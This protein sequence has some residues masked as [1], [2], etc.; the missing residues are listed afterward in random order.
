MM[1]NLDSTGRSQLSFDVCLVRCLPGIGQAIDMVFQTCWIHA[2]QFGIALGVCY[3]CLATVF[4]RLAA[5]PETAIAGAP[6][7]F[8]V[9][10]T[11]VVDDDRRV[12]VDTELAPFLAVFDAA[13][14]P[15]DEREGKGR[16]A[17]PAQ[18]WVS[19]LQDP[20]FGKSVQEAL[21]A[22]LVS[23]KSL[24]RLET[25]RGSHEPYRISDHELATRL[26]YFL[27]ST[28]PDDE[29]LSVAE[30]NK[31]S[32]P[33]VLE[34]QVKRMMADPKASA[35]ADNFAGQ[36]LE[37][38]NLDSIAPDPVKFPAWGQELKEE[39]RTETRMFFQYVLTENRPIS[40]FVNAKYTFLNGMAS[41]SANFASPMYS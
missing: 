39:F 14:S 41:G 6:Y 40:D 36:W 27:W 19:L 16:P 24:Y 9:C 35:F 5:W 28:M 22:I 29:L 32:E 37:V 11:V 31:L 18:R 12:V 7:A 21:K 23:P 26:A 8:R 4:P 10:T 1:I 33:A 20:R 2:T 17:P 15:R 3:W 34:A 38:R 30:S 25:A 13:Y